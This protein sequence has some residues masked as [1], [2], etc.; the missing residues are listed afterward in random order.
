MQLFTPGREQN[1]VIIATKEP[2]D[3]E[4]RDTEG[5]HRNCFCKVSLKYTFLFKYALFLV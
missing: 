3:S 5:G 1:H 2:R 4:H